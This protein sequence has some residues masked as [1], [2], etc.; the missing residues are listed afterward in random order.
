MAKDVEQTDDGG[1]V[2]AFGEPDSGRSTEI[3]TFEPTGNGDFRTDWTF[4]GNA[5]FVFDVEQTRDGGFVSAAADETVRRFTPPEPLSGTPGDDTLEADADGVTIFGG[6]GDDILTSKFNNTALNGEKGNDDL[7]TDLSVSTDSAEALEGSTT[8][9]GGQ[10]EDTLEATV[11][12]EGGSEVRATTKLDGGDQRDTITA[13]AVAARSGETDLLETV[14]EID[15]GGGD[16]T[17]DASAVI[18]LTS[19]TSNAKNVISG[20]GGNDDIEATA[21]LDGAPSESSVTNIVDGG[22][23]HDTISLKAIGD[24]HGLTTQALNEV[25][26]G[27]GKD[28]ITAEAKVQ[29]NGGRTATNVLEGGSGD[30]TLT[31]EG[32]GNS[33]TSG[34]EVLNTLRGGSGDDTMVA[35]GKT[36]NSFG[37][38]ENTLR[39]GDGDD[40]M[41]ATGEVVRGSQPEGTVENDLAGGDGNDILTATVVQ[42][43]E[44]RSVLSGGAGNDELT[45]NG[46]DANELDGGRGQDTLIGGSGD[47]RLDG[48]KDDDTLVLSAGADTLIGGAG[49]DTVEV[50]GSRDDYAFEDDKSTLVA[51]NGDE[52]TL[53]SVEAVAFE[54]TTVSLGQNSQPPNANDDN[55]TTPAG[56]AVTIDVL[57]NDS[58]SDSDE[59]TIE[60]PG[61]PANGTA[62]VAAGNSIRYTPDAGFSGT[63]TFT[64]TV[65]D[66]AGN[67]ARAE[68]AVAVEDAD[69]GTGSVGP[70]PPRSEGLN[71]VVTNGEAQTLRVPFAADLRGTAA[72]ET[73]QVP[74]GGTLAFG[75]NTG[76]TVEFAAPLDA[77]E[78]S[79]SGNTITFA[80]GETEATI[81]LNGDVDLAFAD[82]GTTATIQS[83]DGG[84]TTRLGSQTLDGDFNP[85]AIF[86]DPDAA[87]ALSG[88]P[89]NTPPASSTPN[90]VVLNGESQ[91]LRVPFAAEVRGTAEAETVQVPDGGL[92]EFA[93]NTGDEVEFAGDLADHGFS[94]S[95]NVV[96]VTGPSG[97]RADVALNADV[98]LAF[99]DGATTASIDGQTARVGGQALD[100]TFDPGSVPLDA[101]DIS[102]LAGAGG[103]TG[104]PER[105]PSQ[106]G[107]GPTVVQAGTAESD[108]INGNQDATISGNGGEDRFI[109][110]QEDTAVTIDDFANGDQVFFGDGLTEGDI[111]VTNGSFGDGEL[112]LAGGQASVTLTNL[113]D[114]EDVILNPGDSDTGFQGVFGDDALAFG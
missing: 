74:A 75:G 97:T 68:I 71:I 1:F 7:T 101:D 35:D 114:D 94:Q 88:G 17:I 9:N 66:S 53:Q 73:V 8:Q 27:N 37:T 109:V 105:P 28:E 89:A 24:F 31:A 91:T 107:R 46:G 102:A 39:G 85:G 87:S 2:A 38:V 4:T 19:G 59:L 14:N 30:D 15:G 111:S 47:D 26:G 81:A 6:A 48:G 62:E 64:Y 10:G 93:G 23:G 20:G 40:E 50:S 32:F 42:A 103:S 51:P 36:I 58:D 21:E 16:D 34:A 104:L 77:F 96:S 70:N 83:G 11:R 106:G 80:N 60:D 45:V 18:N 3:F 95:G 57:A 84:F 5:A 78:V 13:N 69:G 12:A 29:S 22:G 33:N 112:Q 82:G 61:E 108:N 98:K 99:A 54:D 79:A 100:D 52:S 65:A 63:E 86:L 90:L 113:A 43:E 56:E 55:A 67:T 44:G 72:D 76:D 49:T 25:T 41:R 110:N 92:L